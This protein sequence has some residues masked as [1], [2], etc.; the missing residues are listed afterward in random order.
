MRGIDGL[1][2][3]TISG[4]HTHEAGG[5]DDPG[6]AVGLERADQSSC[7]VVEQT[8]AEPQEDGAPSSSNNPRIIGDLGR[9]DLTRLPPDLVHLPLDVFDMVAKKL[10]PI[11]LVSV[12][13]TSSRLRDAAQLSA[14]V[15]GRRQ[16]AIQVQFVWRRLTMPPFGGVDALLNP[17]VIRSLALNFDC[18]IGA[19]Q[20]GL[21]VLAEQ[22]AAPTD[23]VLALEGLAVGMAELAPALQE[24]LVVIAEQLDEPAHRASA[25]QSLGP[26][27]AGLAPALQQR[28]V[29][30]AE[31][32][33]EPAHRAA[34]LHALGVGVAGRAP[35]LQ[36]RLVVIAEQLDEPAHRFWALASL[37]AGL[38][39][40]APELQQRLVVLADGLATPADRA[41]AFAALLPRR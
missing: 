40:L 1:G 11:D 3:G 35:E 8:R 18:L 27:M 25:L 30:I 10:R 36:Q 33:D 7:F 41:Q 6:P 39:G 2:K 31:Q 5:A 28:L 15:H 17:H 19:Q 22:L 29:V 14:E 12:S 13:Q 21:V 38:A 32:L 9:P 4:F 16:R 23:R 34:A 20:E 37:C 24:R 26:G